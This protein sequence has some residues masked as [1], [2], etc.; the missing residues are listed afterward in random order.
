MI[1]TLLHNINY[2][3][4]LYERFGCNFVNLLLVSTCQLLPLVLVPCQLP[5]HDHDHITNI[6]DLTSIGLQSL[7]GVNASF[8]HISICLR[9]ASKC[10][11]YCYVSVWL[12]VKVT[13]IF[14]FHF[15]CDWRENVTGIF[16]C[17]SLLTVIFMFH[18]PY[19]DVY[20]NLPI[21]K[22]IHIQIQIKD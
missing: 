14:I 19:M 13:G 7:Q 6:S 22:I 16:L 17:F 5:P 1:Q 20:F 2:R 9:L 15:A 12:Q 3:I 11:R 4:K 21:S 8:F 10:Y 18:L